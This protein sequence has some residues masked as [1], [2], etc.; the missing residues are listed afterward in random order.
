MSGP[1]QR[2]DL[3]TV[4]DLRTGIVWPGHVVK[5]QTGGFCHVQRDSDGQ[6][7]RVNVGFV[8]PRK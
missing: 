4:A 2:G 6:V 7:Y 5:A 3:V 8:S 1:L